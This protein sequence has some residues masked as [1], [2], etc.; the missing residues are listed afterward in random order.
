[1]KTIYSHITLNGLEFPI[2]LGWPDD[3][4]SSKQIVQLDVHLSFPKPPKGSESDDLNDTYC[5]DIL[6]TKIK[7]NIL[8]RQFR[9][10]EH[11]GHE[12]YHIIKQALPP[13]IA[14]SLRIKKQTS[15]RG[16]TGGVTFFYGDETNIW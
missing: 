4:I 15:I 12:I 3:E 5:Y 9:L 7:E 11:L 2:H 6:V 16:L 13:E 14:V 8:Q 10:L 1:M